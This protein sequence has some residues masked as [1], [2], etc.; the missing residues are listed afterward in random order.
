MDFESKKVSNSQVWGLSR[1]AIY[2]CY[3]Y[4]WTQLRIC[5]FWKT[6]LNCRSKFFRDT[7]TNVFRKLFWTLKTCLI[8]V[9]EPWEWRQFEPSGLIQSSHKR[10]TRKSK[11]LCS[12]CILL[13]LN[14]LRLGFEFCRGKISDFEG[15]LKFFHWMWTQ[16]SI[17]AVRNEEFWGVLLNIV[18][19][20]ILSKISTFNE[21]L[22]WSILI[23]VTIF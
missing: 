22:N 13:M 17:N 10:F 20:T 18:S 4:N 5:P 8:N 1:S 11:A 6:F 9:A 3:Y 2:G 7:P 16:T 23:K 14:F 19:R 15:F 12:I 21:T